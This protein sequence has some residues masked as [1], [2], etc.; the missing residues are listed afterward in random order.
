M[1]LPLH[2]HAAVGLQG[3]AVVFPILAGPVDIPCY[4]VQKSQAVTSS[5]T[6]VQV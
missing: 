6:S 5:Q 3:P 2:V 4:S 1:D